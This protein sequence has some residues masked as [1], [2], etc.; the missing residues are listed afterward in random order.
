[1]T[2]GGISTTIDCPSTLSAVGDDCVVTTPQFTVQ[3]GVVML[4]VYFLEA[5]SFSSDPSTTETNT[6]ENVVYT[7][8]GMFTKIWHI[9]YIVYFSY[10]FTDP[11]HDSPSYQICGYCSGTCAGATVC[12]SYSTGTCIPVYDHCDGSLL[13]YG[14]FSQSEDEYTA[15]LF[16]DVS[17][18]D[19]NN[20]KSFTTTCN[21]CIPAMNAEVSCPSSSSSLVPALLPLLLAV[22]VL[23]VI[24]KV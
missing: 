16:D 22:V 7:P 24:N 4:S 10:I 17:C 12:Q 1:M 11:T 23:I 2:N 14:I 13:A 15:D 8:P 21:T 19:T 20:E 6:F 5:K 3:P 18:S 9:I